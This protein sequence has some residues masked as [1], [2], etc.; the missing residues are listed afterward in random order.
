MFPTYKSVHTAELRGPWTRDQK[1][2]VL[3]RREDLNH[4]AVSGNKWWKL[5]YNLVEAVRLNSKTILAFGGAYSNMVY[6]TAAAAHEMGMNSIGVIRG[7][8]TFPTNHTLSFAKKMGMQLHFVSREA[9]RKKSEQHFIES[10]KGKFGDFYMLPEGG[11]N[12]LAVKGCMEFGKKIMDETEFDYLCLPVGTGGT[13]AGIIAGIAGKKEVV[14]FSSL[15]GGEFLENE[16]KPLLEKC[17]LTDPGN[18]SIETQFHFGGYGKAND[19]LNGF[20]RQQLL[21]NQL[22]LDPVYTSKMMYG[23]VRL[24]SE[25]YFKPGST[26]L[27]IHTGGL[28]TAS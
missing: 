9:Y 14:G 6:A 21:E 23:I 11:T 28:Q 8:E 25:G 3:V 12:E 20:I 10:L 7:E 13:A 1:I 26:V 16:I 19:E 24:I 27:A 2:R 18:W 22:P 17:R 4:D 5:K 15:K